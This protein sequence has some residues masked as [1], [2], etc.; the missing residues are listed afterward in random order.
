MAAVRWWAVKI[1]KQNVVAKSNA[2][3]GIPDRRF[4]TNQDKAKDITREQLDRVR[5]VTCT[6]E[7]GTAKSLR[8][9]TGRG[10][11]VPAELC[12]PGRSPH[13]QGQLDQGRETTDHPDPDRP[14]TGRP[15]SGQWC[16][17]RGQFFWIS[18]NIDKYGV[19]YEVEILNKDVSEECKERAIR[20]ALSARYI[21]AFHNDKPVNVKLLKA[22]FGSWVDKI[23]FRDN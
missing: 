1:N 8:A 21:P 23:I 3:Y 10:D 5:D 6:H 18:A 11:E 16:G 9:S 22:R 12:R 4:V 20:S 7:S 15:L 17:G 14:A 19:P 13:A 2:H